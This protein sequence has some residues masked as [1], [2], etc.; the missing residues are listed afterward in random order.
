MSDRRIAE[1]DDPDDAYRFAKLKGP[2]YTVCGGIQ[3][4]WAVRPLASRQTNLGNPESPP[5]SHV[6]E[7][8]FYE[9][10]E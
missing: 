8:E 6:D 5:E 10:E 2:D 4:M 9:D 7:D 1:F 3:R